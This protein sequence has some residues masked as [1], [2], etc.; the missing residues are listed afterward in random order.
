MLVF[1][2]D[3]C[4]RSTQKRYSGKESCGSEIQSRFVA[5]CGSDM[6][7]PVHPQASHMVAQNALQQIANY[8]L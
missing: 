4:K 2:H 6:M 1:P 8:L 5:I 3:N 7:F